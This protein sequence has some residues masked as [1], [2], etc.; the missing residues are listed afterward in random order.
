MMTDAS[1]TGIAP[2][3]L[4]RIRGV[5][6]LSS[7]E[8]LPCWVGD[9]L[10]HSPWVVVR[11]ARSAGARVPVGVRGQSRAARFA[12]FTTGHEILACVTPQAI[13]TGRMWRS[14]ARRDGLAAIAALPAVEE[15]MRAHGLGA[16]WGPTGSVGFELVCGQAAAHPASDLDLVV[17][18]EGPP[19]AAAARALHAALAALPVRADVLLEMPHGAVALADCIGT[20]EKWVLRTADGPRWISAVTD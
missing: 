3:A 1:V 16:R 13:A 19:S 14:A 7:S 20:R 11:R 2:H 5:E 9:S 4:V 15:I 8:A 18:L 6:A 10:R 17:Q 12:A